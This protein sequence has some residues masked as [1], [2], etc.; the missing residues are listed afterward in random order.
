MK[1]KQPFSLLEIIIGLSFLSIISVFLLSQLFSSVKLLTKTTEIK[2]TAL[3]RAFI[4][5]RLST[6]LSCIE[7]CLEPVAEVSKSC[8]YT[9][10][11]PQLLHFIFYQKADPD[12]LFSGF[13]QASLK[14]SNKQLLLEMHPFDSETPQSC[15][16]EILLENVESMSLLFYK[17]PQALS[18]APS[19]LPEKLSSWGSDF[20]DLPLAFI[21]DLTLSN[22]EHLTY[23]FYI[24]SK[25]Q[26]IYYE[27]AP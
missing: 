21:L 6:L 14:L 10:N 3:T 8:F 9:G 20:P 7:P 1:K 22:D 4:Q 19:R 25:I 13:I 5:E 12:P 11:S 16:Q 26:P 15:R 24:S 17:R 2:K 27:E 18:S 23:T